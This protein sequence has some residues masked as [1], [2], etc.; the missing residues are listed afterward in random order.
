M[1][2]LLT[3]SYASAPIRA[4]R[5]GSSSPFSPRRRELLPDEPH[6][7]PE[8]FRAFPGARALRRGSLRA[9]VPPGRPLRLR[10][11]RAAGEGGRP[12]DAA[13]VSQVRPAADRA[14][15]ARRVHVFPA[16]GVEKRLEPPHG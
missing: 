9:R 8:P 2:R 10:R 15:A 3:L 1:H 5:R 6:S 13:R 7:Q 14:R 4:L 16:R 11:V 12:E